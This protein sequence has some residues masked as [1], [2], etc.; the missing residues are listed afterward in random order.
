MPT[1]ARLKASKEAPNKQK[2][3]RPQ[4][5]VA[6]NKQ[7]KDAAKKAGLNRSERET[8]KRELELESREM[9]IDHSYQD[10]VDMAHE[11]KK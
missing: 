9:G 8:L 1:E 3:G 2:K 11:I 4:T 7:V 6:Q 5:N 10:I